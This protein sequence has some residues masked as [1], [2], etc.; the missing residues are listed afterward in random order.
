MIGNKGWRTGVTVVA[1]TALVW[2][3]TLPLVAQIGAKS[4]SSAASRLDAQP[5]SQAD[6]DFVAK[7]S[8]VVCMR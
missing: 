5:A 3:A 2:G 6:R 7:V 4:P 1:G 8:Q